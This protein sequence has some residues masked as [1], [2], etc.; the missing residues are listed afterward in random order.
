MFGMRIGGRLWRTSFPLVLLELG[1]GTYALPHTNGSYLPNALF[2]VIRN[3][4]TQLHEVDDENRN[5][6][7]YTGPVG[8]L[9]HS[10]TLGPCACRAVC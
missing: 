10:C 5:S 8:M 6:L 4:R 9:Y 2:H 3:D 7:A 1:P